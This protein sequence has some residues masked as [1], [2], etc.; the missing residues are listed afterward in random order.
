MVIVADIAVSAKRA[1]FEQVAV[2]LRRDGHGPAIGG[3]NPQLRRDRVVPVVS[4]IP[5]AA[6]LS[7][8]YFGIKSPR[9]S[10]AIVSSVK[11]QNLGHLRAPVKTASA[12]PAA[13]HG[14]ANGIDAVLAAV[15]KKTAAIAVDI[16]GA[17]H[18]RG[19]VVR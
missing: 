14:T 19:G 3:G 2:T 17:R 12:K 8:R 15:I 11:T 9:V 10:V 13:R 18:R 7:G 1:D 6:N 5:D 16:T 4:F